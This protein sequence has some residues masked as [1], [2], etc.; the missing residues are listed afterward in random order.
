MCGWHR[1]GRGPIVMREESLMRRCLIFQNMPRSVSR[2]KLRFWFNENRVPVLQFCCVLLQT[3]ATCFK[4]HARPRQVDFLWKSKTLNTF[5][6]L[7][8]TCLGRGNNDISCSTSTH[9][10]VCANHTAAIWTHGRPGWKLS[11][12]GSDS[13]REGGQVSRLYSDSKTSKCCYQVKILDPETLYCSQQPWQKTYMFVNSEKTSTSGGLVPVA[14]YRAAGVICE[15]W[16]ILISV[17]AISELNK[18]IASVTNAVPCH[19][20]VL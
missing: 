13:N 20:L 10:S 2:N 6:L 3:K 4:C 7:F 11:R 9:T 16:P 8:A 12:T 19:S 5:W 14:N 15:L 1:G 17:K 18:S